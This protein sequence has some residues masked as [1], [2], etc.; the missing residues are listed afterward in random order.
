[1]PRR[2]PS[3]KSALS[4]SSRS[5]DRVALQLAHHAGHLLGR[6]LDARLHVELHVADPAFEHLDRD[7][8][9]GQVLLGDV[10][11]REEQAL[12]LQRDFDVL[13]GVFQVG[14]ALVG[15]DVFAS[16]G[17]RGSARAASMPAMR[18]PLTVTLPPPRQ[19]APRPRA[20]A[21]SAGRAWVDGAGNQRWA[22]PAAGS[23][24]HSAAVA[25]VATGRAP[26]HVQGA[27]AGSRP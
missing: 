11:L 2:S 24:R 1:M 4:I 9:V 18:K 13:G 19:S 15:A 20:A 12:A 25:A 8:A 10:G 26:M 14:Q 27:T 7:D 3:V 16:S 21:T 23:I 22:G 17:I 6:D 5:R